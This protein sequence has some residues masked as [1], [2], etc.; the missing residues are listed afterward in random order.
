MRRLWK[1]L[2][3]TSFEHGAFQQHTSAASS[4]AHSDI[5]AQTHHFPRV[6]AAGV[7]LPQAHHV[8]NLDLTR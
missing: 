8:P 6:A 7:R 4:A 5:H 3:H 1:D 2:T